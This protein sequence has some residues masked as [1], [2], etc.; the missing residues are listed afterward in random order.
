MIGTLV[1]INMSTLTPETI[2]F[3]CIMLLFAYMSY[4][5]LKTL[6]SKCKIELKEKRRAE[7]QEYLIENTNTSEDQIV[8]HDKQPDSIQNVKVAHESKHQQFLKEDEDVVPNDYSPYGSHI[9]GF[10]SD[11]FIQMQTNAI[12]KISFIIII[13]ATPIISLL[14]GVGTTRSIIGVDHCSKEDIAIC[15]ISFLVL[16][17][18]SYL[19]TKSIIRRNKKAIL[20]SNQIKF[21]LKNTTGII[22][23]SLIIGLLGSW[24]GVAISTMSNL[25]LLSLGLNPFVGGPTSLAIVFLTSGSSS[26][27]FFLDGVIDLPTF[28][29]CSLIIVTISILTRFTI[30]NMMVRTKKA[31]IPVL[32]VLIIT[33]ISIPGIVFKILPP[34]LKDIRDGVDFMKI[35][36]ASFCR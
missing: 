2:R 32:C 11:K 12:D 19:N 33:V 7:K 18:I 29:I 8:E 23:S 24:L 25:Y 15:S 26:I 20:S 34:I 3:T 21:N 17:W 28:V 6:I 27:L 16:A 35:D 10:E 14:R 30:Y 36:F 1:G 22:V 5:G 4:Q 31:S 9:A 13:L